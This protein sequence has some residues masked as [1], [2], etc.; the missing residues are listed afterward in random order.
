M[1]QNEADQEWAQILQQAREEKY[2]G[3][4]DYEETM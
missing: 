3:D 1:L 2:L 4:P